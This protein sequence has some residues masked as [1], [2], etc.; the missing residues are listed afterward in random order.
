[1]IAPKMFICRYEEIKL[2]IMGIAT[3]IF[4]VIAM[5]TSNCGQINL[6]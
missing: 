5:R 6:I 1:M 4:I 2:D 3:V